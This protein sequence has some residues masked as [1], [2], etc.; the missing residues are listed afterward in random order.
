MLLD[1]LPIGYDPASK[2]AIC[3]GTAAPG[4]DDDD[5]PLALRRQHPRH[6]PQQCRF[7]GPRPAQKQDGLA[8]RC[9][10]RDEGRAAR[11]GAPDAAREADD[12]A[13]AVAQAADTVQRAVDARSVVLTELPNLLPKTSVDAAGQSSFWQDTER[14]LDSDRGCAGS[15]NNDEHQS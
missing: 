8:A 4:V 10:V 3:T 12:A 15:C 14:L 9:E 11:H 13:V 2:A 7:A 6:I 5:T 1:R